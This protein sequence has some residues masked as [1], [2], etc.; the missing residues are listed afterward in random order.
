M[1]SIGRSRYLRLYALLLTAAIFFSPVGHAADSPKQ[2]DPTGQRAYDAAVERMKERQR[3]RET[4]GEPAGERIQRLEADNKRLKEENEKLRL[5][6][7]QT[8]K[9]LNQIG[10]LTLK[11]VGQLRGDMAPR[12]IN[13]GHVKI[14]T[15]ASFARGDYSL[16]FASNRL[17]VDGQAWRQMDQESHNKL[18]MMIESTFQLRISGVN[19]KQTGASLA[20]MRP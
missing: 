10:D 11:I 5:Q 3:K 18:V 19:D 4:D 2:A 12:V 9:L 17:I 20:V 8:V 16:D 14:A 15:L 1:N 7:A 13:E 6:W